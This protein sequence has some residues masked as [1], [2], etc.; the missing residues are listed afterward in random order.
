MRE[1]PL[2]HFLPRTCGESKLDYSHL[3]YEV[4]SGSILD[5]FAWIIG[6]SGLSR[7]VNYM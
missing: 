2:S 3:G 7:A 4:T 6:L 1:L 5:I